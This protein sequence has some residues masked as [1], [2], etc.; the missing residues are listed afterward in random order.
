MK[1]QGIQSF[2]HIA[3]F[4]I[5]VSFLVIHSAQADSVKVGNGSYSLVRPADCAPLP[6]SIF[7]A[8]NLEGATPTNQWWSSLV[9]EKYSQNLFPHPLAMNCNEQGLAVAY[10]GSGIVG[11]GGHIMGGGIGKTG[12]FVISHS[13]VSEFPETRLVDYSDWFITAE[14]RKGESFL[15][16]TFGHGS[17][18]IFNRIAGGS[19]VL[20]FAHQ[21]V[22]WS[23]KEGDTTIGVT[24]RGN[25]YGIYGAKESGWA[26]L[27]TE[28]FTNISSKG[29]FTVALLPDSNDA[30][31]AQFEQCAHHHVT[32][33]SFS[34][35]T[36]EGQLK[37]KYQFEVEALEGAGQDTLFALYPHQWKYSGVAL[38]GESYRSVRG[39][40]KL[41]KGAGFATEVP[42]QGLLPMFPAEGIAD[43][44][45]L[46]L[47]LKEE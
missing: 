44:K 10:P 42:I 27:K 36:V 24:V 43:P 26:G 7:S 22:V 28:T 4:S 29:Y 35:T 3:Q 37:T 21:P 1:K 39:E 18:Y 30:T 6:D 40:M 2:F 20:R 25:H 8:D 41:A 16:S 11:A 31:L 34:A 14:F 19:A 38:T 17:P 15:R 12:D 45:Q 33:T 32:G 47:Y 5:S 46:V 23:G 9:W 13:E